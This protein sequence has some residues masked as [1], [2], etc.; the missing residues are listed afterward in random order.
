MVTEQIDLTSG[1]YQAERVHRCPSR[2]RIIH[3]C[4]VRF[5]P[6]Q[7]A[8]AVARTIDGNDLSILRET[9]HD[10]DEFPAALRALMQ[11]EQGA[12]MTGLTRFAQMDLTERPVHKAASNAGGGMAHRA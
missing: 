3:D 2:V 6:W 9:G 4:G 5:R 11:T 10:F 8:L 12:F 7:I 1:F